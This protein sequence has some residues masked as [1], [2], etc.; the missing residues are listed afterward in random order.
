MLH[1]VMYVSELRRTPERTVSNRS[2]RVF[3]SESSSSAGSV[4]PV[5]SSWTERLACLRQTASSY[6]GLVSHHATL[7]CA[8]YSRNRQ[9]HDNK[10][11]LIQ[12]WMPYQRVRKPL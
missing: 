4:L 6:E 8:T 2:G 10:L 5:N 3:G 9:E 7:E 12:H 11:F 1:S